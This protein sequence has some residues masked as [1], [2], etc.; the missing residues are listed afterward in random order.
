MTARP[1]VVLI[2]GSGPNAVEA[3]DIP[4]A[5]F[6]ALVVI[7]NAW[8]VRDDW[9]HLVYPHDFPDDR[10]PPAVEPA[11]T[12]VTEADFVPAQNRQG[13]FV[14]A[15]GTMA[16]TAGYWALDVM[17]PRVMAFLGCDMVYPK[18]GATHFYGTGA[19]DPLRADITLQ[20]LPA[21]SARLAILAA[22]QGC[23][24]VNL[25]VDESQLVFTRALAQELREMAKGAPS[26][27]PE[28]AA[29]AREAALGYMSETGRYWEEPERFDADELE[30]LDAL[31]L[32]AWREGTAR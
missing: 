13:G 22:R 2:L 30:A 11:Q 20:S 1:E 12:L 24:C 31:W 21:K 14:Y 5:T 6:D 9:S 29:D 17:R 10:H 26:E 15:G 3:K 19:P 32:E 7:N 27:W 18:T 23:H 28:T 8:R 16:Y 25:S 4:S